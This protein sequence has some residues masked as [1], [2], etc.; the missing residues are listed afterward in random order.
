MAMAGSSAAITVNAVVSDP[1]LLAP[2]IPT[3]VRVTTKIELLPSDGAVARVKLLRMGQDGIAK[4][5]ATMRD[6]GYKWDAVA[7]DGIWTAEIAIHESGT[8]GLLLQ[9]SASLRGSEQTYLS[10]ITQ[11][12]FS[13]SKEKAMLTVSVTGFADNAP[14]PERAPASD[15]MRIEING[16][17]VGQTNEQGKLTVEVNA[18]PLSIKAITHYERKEGQ[19]QYSDKYPAGKYPSGLGWGGANPSPG[20]KV[21]VEVKVDNKEDWKDADATVDEISEGLLPSTASTFTMRFFNE[22]NNEI[23]IPVEMVAYGCQIHGEKGA[24]ENIEEYQVVIQSDGSIRIPMTL[25]EPFLRRMSGEVKLHCSFSSAGDE[26]YAVDVKF[27]Y[28]QH[29]LQGK[30]VAP[31]SNATLPVGNVLVTAKLVETRYEVTTRTDAEGNFL[32][33]LLPEGTFELRTS[34]MT[35]GTIY[36]ESAFV[37]MSG[38]V[39]IEVFFRGEV[40]RRKGVSPSR[41]VQEGIAP[42]PV[43]DAAEVRRLERE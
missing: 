17:V 4:V 15:N 28:G 20:E 13:S 1:P 9:A 32:F 24:S 18:E 36:E 31:P 19:P 26:L 5:I 39:S 42:P 6:D 30:L 43:A 21:E 2:N 40:E 7:G 33:P 10:G 34:T 37:P 14:D 41:L 3:R 22:K 25:L 23:R 27:F 38:N 12:P 16:I 35:G 8:S 11:I 29:R